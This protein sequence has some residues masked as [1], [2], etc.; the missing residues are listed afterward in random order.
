[1]AQAGFAAELYLPNGGSEGFAAVAE[2]TRAATDAM[3]HEGIPIRYR[4]A[5]LL[6][7]DE[8][9]FCFFDAP[10]AAVIREASE[11]ADVVFDR[12]VPATADGIPSTPTPG[13]DS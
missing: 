11:R 1:M 7:D 12:V 9:C 5:I 10:S 3:A 4:G 6:T 8:T 13:K 2:R